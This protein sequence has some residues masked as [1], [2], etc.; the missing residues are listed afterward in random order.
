MVKLR[1]GAAAFPSRRPCSGLRC[2]SLIYALRVTRYS[3]ALE[4]PRMP[5]S[6]D[7]R[8][9]FESV[10]QVLESELANAGV[11]VTVDARAR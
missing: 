1:E 8:S 6:A 7:D 5:D 3:R 11:H 4:G 10:I 2:R 9:A